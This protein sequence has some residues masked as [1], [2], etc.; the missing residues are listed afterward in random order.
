MSRLDPAFKAEGQYAQGSGTFTANPLATAV[1]LAALEELEKAGTYERLHQAGNRL[2]Q[3]L[4]RVCELLE[5]PALVSSQGPTVDVKFTDRDEVWDYR[6]TLDQDHQLHRLVDIG[7]MRRG[8]FG[9]PEA[10]FY[11]SLAHTDRE[12]DETV[13]AFEDTL[14]ESR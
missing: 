11:V 14:R 9:I 8:I 6:S 12:I 5:V 2:R 4:Q 3:G 7:L 13:E 10:G 1:G